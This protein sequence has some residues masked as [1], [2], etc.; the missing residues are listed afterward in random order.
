MSEDLLARNVNSAHKSPTK[1][2]MVENVQSDEVVFAMI[3]A[4]LTI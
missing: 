4:L 1:A 3:E 2:V